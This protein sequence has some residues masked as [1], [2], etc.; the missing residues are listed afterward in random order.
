MP[1]TFTPD[2][3]HLS[4]QAGPDQCKP[5]HLSSQCASQHHTHTPH[6]LPLLPEMPPYVVLAPLPIPG[7]G[8]A[9]ALR[10]ISP[11][12]VLV[13]VT[14][15]APP[16]NNHRGSYKSLNQP[17]CVHEITLRCCS[18]NIRTYKYSATDNPAKKITSLP[19]PYL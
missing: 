14:P 6:T 5:R 4:V 2:L 17:H 9:S 8:V 15:S 3:V 12:T 10:A 13:A 7:Q 16:T 19:G 18:S 1:S 11:D